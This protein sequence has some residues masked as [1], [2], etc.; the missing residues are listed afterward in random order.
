MQT[1]TVYE[2][3]KV[4]YDS[5]DNES[6]ESSGIFF[7]AE[8]EAISFVSSERYYRAFSVRANR[9]NKGTFNDY[10]R[11]RVIEIFDSVKEYDKSADQRDKDIALGKL[12]ERE[13]QLLGL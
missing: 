2:V 10:V 5:E 12:T 3:I 13:R 7:F 9:R 8:K 1:H 6:Y 11:K 4:V